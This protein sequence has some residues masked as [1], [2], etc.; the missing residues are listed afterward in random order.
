MNRPDDS[1]AIDRL[2]DA[3]RRAS[4]RRPLAGIETAYRDLCWGRHPRATVR[5]L[6]ASLLASIVGL[7][8]AVWFHSPL[9]W[10]AAGILI[11]TLLLLY[12]APG[13]ESEGKS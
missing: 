5:T 1:T 2:I 10:A 3:V 9:S 4:R 13:D 11:A 7:L 6:L 8:V 12:F